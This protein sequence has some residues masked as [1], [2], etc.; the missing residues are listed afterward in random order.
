MPYRVHV[1]PD[2]TAQIFWLKNRR[3][4]EW[5]DAWQLEATLGKYMI[6][7]RPM[8]EEEWIRKRAATVIDVTPD[9]SAVIPRPRH[10]CCGVFHDEA[11]GVLL[12]QPGRLDVGQWRR[13]R[14]VQ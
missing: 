1:P 11:L 14:L 12:D 5:R 9:G 8:T 6:S 10:L 13:S 4:S 7:D 2:V 3:P